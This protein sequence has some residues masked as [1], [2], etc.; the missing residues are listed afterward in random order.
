MDL[1]HTTRMVTSVTATMAVA[2]TFTDSIYLLS[3]NRLKGIPNSMNRSN[4]PKQS[5]ITQLS[6]MRTTNTTSSGSITTKMTTII[7]VMRGELLPISSSPAMAMAT[8]NTSKACPKGHQDPTME[9]NLIMSQVSTVQDSL[10]TIIRAKSSLQL[11]LT[12]APLLTLVNNQE[13]EEGQIMR[14]P[15]KVAEPVL[16]LAT[17]ALRPPSATIQSIISEEAPTGIPIIVIEA[18]RDSHLY[19]SGH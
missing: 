16:L 4:L 9:S 7:T 8:P 14:F 11:V 12:E 2:D 13:L 19:V 15:I 3:K 6:R 18:S 5:P 1:I 17:T 10:M